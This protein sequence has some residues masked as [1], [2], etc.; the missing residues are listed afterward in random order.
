MRS[1]LQLLVIG[2]VLAW[3]TGC[4][5]R[6]PAP[7]MEQ[8]K[9]N[10][11]GDKAP[12]KAPYA[13]RVGG[14]L[15]AADKGQ[16]SR[17]LEILGE[18][19][20]VNDKD[21]QGETALMKAAANGHGALVTVL[22][23]RGAEVSE[24]DRKGQTALMRAA[25]KGHLPILKVL[26]A[27]N[28]VLNAPAD[29]L[30]AAGVNVKLPDLPLRNLSL[31]SVDV[32]ARDQG[33]QTALVK[34][35]LHGQTEA[36]Q[37]LIEAQVDTDGKDSQGETVLTLAAALGHLDIVN[38]L[39]RQHRGLLEATNR[40]GMTPLMVAAAKGQ[41]DIVKDLLEKYRWW[42]QPAR[43][44]PT[45]TARTTTARQRCSTRKMQGSKRWPS[46]S[47]NTRPSTWAMQV[48]RRR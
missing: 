19:A 26:L 35:V 22:L 2:T 14:L 24:K 36:V 38:A 5:N 23:A 43:A 6:K 42:Q 9:P 48:V 47:G 11:E 10:V 18:G 40:T 41:L 28:T 7:A 1:L 44:W 33:G 21:D 16:V 31:G 30:K 13:G 27:P 46:C 4:G 17:V 3:I 29:V 37:L 39:L 8:G 20:D 32:N 25:E 34:A 12:A 15:E 45:R